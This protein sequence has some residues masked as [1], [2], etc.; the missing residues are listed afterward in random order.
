MFKPLFPGEVFFQGGAFL[1][2][3]IVLSYPLISLC[4]NGNSVTQFLSASLD[5][6]SW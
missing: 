2:L 6:M 4:V 1:C 3:A 5:W